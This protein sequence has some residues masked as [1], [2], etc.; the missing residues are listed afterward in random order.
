MLRVF[1]E[2]ARYVDQC[3]TSDTKI[4]TIDGNKNI[5]EITTNDMVLT[6]E[7]KYEKVLEN[8][9]YKKE[10]RNLIIIETENGIEKVTEEHLYLIIKNGKNVE[11]IL[12]KIKTGIF[13]PIWVKA[14]DLTKNDLLINI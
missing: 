13:T 9:K 6:S 1:N 2:T 7:G 5:S 10:N 3:F 12:D 14:I 8:K 4:K 11:N